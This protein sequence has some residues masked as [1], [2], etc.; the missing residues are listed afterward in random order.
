MGA[1]LP[2]LVDVWLAKAFNAHD[3]EAAAAMYHPDASVVRVDQAHGTDAVGRDA[4][5]IRETMVG[6][7]G[8]KPR[9]ELTGKPLGRRVAAVTHL[10]LTLDGHPN[11]KHWH[12]EIAKRPAV[13]RGLAVPNLTGLQTK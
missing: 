2:E 6:Y 7:I 12:Q 13:I 10:G 4:T 9:I 11:L 3:V 1:P 5:G 8:H